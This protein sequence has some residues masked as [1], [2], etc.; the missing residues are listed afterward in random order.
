MTTVTSNTSYRPE[1][2]GLR[3]LSVISVVLYHA[4]CG[5]PG[6]YVGVDVFFVISGFLITRLILKDLETGQFSIAQFWERRIRRIFPALAVMLGVVLVAGCFLLLPT[7]LADLGKS[8]LA[9]SLL[10]ANVYF[11]RDTGYFAAPAEQ[12]L[13]LHTWSLAVEEQFYVVFPVALIALHSLARRSTRTVVASL[14][15]FSLAASVYGAYNHPIASFFLLPTRAWEL[16]AGSLLTFFPDT[17]RLPKPVREGIASFGILAILVAIFQFDQQTLFPGWAALLPVGGAAAFIFANTS[18]G[19]IV[20]RLLSL[21]P[22][23]FVGQISYSLYLW[24]WPIFVFLRCSFG[25][26]ESLPLILSA[27]SL[28]LVMSVLSW[29]FVELPFRRPAAGPGRSTVFASAAVVQ[30]FL[31]GVAFLF[32]MTNG[33]PTRLPEL[34]RVVADSRGLDPGYGCSV[35]ELKTG[36]LPIIGQVN[37]DNGFDFAILGD[38]HAMALAAVFDQVS[39]QRHLQGFVLAANGM[40]PFRLDAEARERNEL[41]LENLARHR[42]KNVVVIVRWDYLLAKCDTFNAL[43]SWLESLQRLKVQRVFMLR[44]V[45]RQPLGDAYRQ[46][47]VASFRFPGLVTLPRTSAAEYQEQVKLED[48]LFDRLPSFGPLAIELVDL[49]AHCFDEAGFSRV[50]ESG[51]A[52]Y[53][54]DDHLSKFGAEVLLYEAVDSMLSQMTPARDPS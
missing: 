49:S 44:Q 11:W 14:A 18:Q 51:R 27:V 29:R 50:F 23:V 13:L 54:D 46:Q 24:H 31:F 16:L 9:Q 33:L 45:P 20:G 25:K 21:L 42:I 6:G 52:L 37:D 53:F 15:L 3:A 26:L 36:R 2:D 8:S 32:W 12:K 41:Y 1:I 47:I 34:Q 38:S 40:S 4:E 22:L 28:S 19:T 10:I 35:D 43:V 48:G 17:L 5:L 30:F 39:K 7:Q